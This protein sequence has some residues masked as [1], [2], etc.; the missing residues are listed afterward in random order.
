L[1]DFV[2]FMQLIAVGEAKGDV[3]ALAAEL[4]SKKANSATITVQLTLKMLELYHQWSTSQ[5]PDPKP[6]QQSR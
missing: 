3:L 1:K 5:E 4:E 6:E 2:D